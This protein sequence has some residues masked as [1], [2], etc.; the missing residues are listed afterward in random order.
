MMPL[1]QSQRIARIGGSLGF[2]AAVAILDWIKWFRHIQ[3]TFFKKARDR[4]YRW[5][6]QSA[7]HATRLNSWNHALRWS[8]MLWGP[9]FQTAMW[10]MTVCSSVLDPKSKRLGRTPMSLDRLVKVGS[11][12]RQFTQMELKCH[13]C[14]NQG[15]SV[16]TIWNN[17]E[18]IENG[19]WIWC[20]FLP[21]LLKLVP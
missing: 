8:K 3:S 11:T 12:G 2:K 17:E 15:S 5:A 16:L 6:L 18:K 9:V 20:W 19:L 14:P 1:I 4:I 13:T 10:L 21:Y 7:R